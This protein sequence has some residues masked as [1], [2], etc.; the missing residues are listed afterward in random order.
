[1]S[2]AGGADEPW[3]VPENVS[4]TTPV[5]M[6]NWASYP[7]GCSTIRRYPNE[8]KFDSG[9]GFAPAA[10]ACS[11]SPPVPTMTSRIPFASTAPLGFSWAKRA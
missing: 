10:A 2:A 6:T 5:E 7:V 3:Q 11:D 9:L 1:M 8:R 4:F